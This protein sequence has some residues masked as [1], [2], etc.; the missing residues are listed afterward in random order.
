MTTRASAAT[1][2]TELARDPERGRVL[3]G[4]IQLSQSFRAF[5]EAAWPLIEPMTAFVPGPHLDALCRH[6]QAVTETH[7]R[8]SA[9]SATEIATYVEQP[10][11]I[12]RLL[13]TIPPRMAKSTI[14]AVL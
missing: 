6:L 7:E 8:L 14:V 10:E 1:L 5:A 9:M 13:I 11:D 4:S 12:R 3:V 2:I